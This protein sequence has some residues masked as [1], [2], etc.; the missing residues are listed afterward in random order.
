LE[1]LNIDKGNKRTRLQH[2]TQVAVWF[3]AAML[4]DVRPLPRHGR[5]ARIRFMTDDEGWLFDDQ[6][7]TFEDGHRLAISVNSGPQFDE[8]ARNG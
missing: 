3:A 6:F 5:P 4:A 7:V 2:E 1:A 8:P